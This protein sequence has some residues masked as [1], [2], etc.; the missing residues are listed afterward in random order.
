V[1]INSTRGLIN[2]L[3]AQAGKIESRLTL[4]QNHDDGEEKYN[5]WK[6]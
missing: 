1:P 2:Y 4:E 3:S 6:T 5:D